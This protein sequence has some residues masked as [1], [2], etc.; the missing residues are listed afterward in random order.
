MNII[1]MLLL[2]YFRKTEV[3]VTNRLFY[4]ASDRQIRSVRNDRLFI[5]RRADDNSYSI[6]TVDL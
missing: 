3:I 5:K 4:P 2:V 1:I 6:S